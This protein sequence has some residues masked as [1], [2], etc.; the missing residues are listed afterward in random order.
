MFTKLHLFAKQHKIEVILIAAILL[1]AAFLRVYNIH[2]YMRFLGDEGRDA[3]A[4]LRMVRYLDVPLIGPGTSVGNMYMGPLYYYM[5]LMPMVLTGLN[6]VSAAVMVAVIGVLSVALLYYMGR[7]WFGPIAG[8]VAAALFAVSY[9]P[10]TFGQS[11]WNPYPMPFFALL[12]VLSLYKTIKD[13]NSKWLIVLGIAVAFALQMH[14][15]GL[16][17][18]PLVGLFW[19][20]A[21]F[22]FRKNSKSLEPFF[23]DTAISIGVFCVLMSPL[24]LFDLKHDFLNY[25]AYIKFLTHR[26][27]TVNLNPLNTLGEMW[28]TYSELYVSR[29]L[30]YGFPKLGI[31]VSIALPFLLV[32]QAAIFWLKRHFSLAFLLLVAWLVLGV[33]GITL[34]KSHIYDHYLGFMIP[35]G[36]LL[37]GMLFATLWG[38]HKRLRPLVLLL[39]FL[40]IGTLVR[41]TPHSVAPGKQLQRTQHIARYIINESRNE[42]F[43]FALIAKSNYD[44][45]YEF[46]FALWHHP[47]TLIDPLRFNETR[48]DQLFVACEDPVCE[49]VNNDRTEIANYGW[50]T[51]DTQTAIDGVKVFRLVPSVGPNE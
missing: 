50:K 43:N 19:L 40:Y 5:M 41:Y 26:E 9:L 32:S 37:V 21:A 24:L 18:L 42:P 14:P 44:D 11:S 23:V 10:I 1:T 22:W 8:L 7:L 17:L 39:V 46:Y 2:Q 3:L 29:F 25:N 36:Y 31:I 49:P 38:L 6:P 51:I 35:A 15:L 27:G 12:V 16:I 48:A 30:S 34:I 33:T 4:V 45:G 47:M 28:T 20:I 13:V